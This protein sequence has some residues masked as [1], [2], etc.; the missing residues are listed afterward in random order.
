METGLRRGEARA[1]LLKVDGKSLSGK[2]LTS[3]AIR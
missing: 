2:I 3:E 1:D